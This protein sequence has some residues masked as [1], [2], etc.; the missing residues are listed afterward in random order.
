MSLPFHNVVEIRIKDGHYE[1]RRCLEH[2]RNINISQVGVKVCP[3]Q[4]CVSCHREIDSAYVSL[5]YFPATSSFLTIMIYNSRILLTKDY[6]TLKEILFP[7]CSRGFNLNFV[8]NI[9]TDLTVINN[10]KRIILYVD[11][12]G[13]NTSIFFLL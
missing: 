9:V 5:I 7:H 11:G 4:I 2:T 3:Q 12:I 13:K 1:P 8:L 6:L 10:Y